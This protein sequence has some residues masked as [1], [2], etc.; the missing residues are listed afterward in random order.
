MFDIEKIIWS[1]KASWK[2]AFCNLKTSLLKT[3][4]ENDFKVFGGNILFECNFS[5]VHIIN[6]HFNN[7]P[8]L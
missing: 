2:N 8:F 7:K 3:L 5:K 1:L 4:Y 6:K